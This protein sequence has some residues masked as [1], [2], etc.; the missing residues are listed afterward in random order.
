[1]NNYGYRM[2]D[3][4]KC[5]NL[6]IL[7]GRTTKDKDKGVCTCKGVSTIDYFL[8]SSHIIPLI[9][10]F[11]VDD[12]SQNLSDAHCPVSLEI[13][14]QLPCEQEHV[15][16]HSKRHESERIKL[17]DETMKDEFLHNTDLNAFDNINENI[18]CLRLERN[19]T[20]NEIDCI[21]ESFNKF[22][23]TSAEKSSGT[24]KISDQS[25]ASSK[26]PSW[27]GRK[28]TKARK[29][30]HTA[31]FQY[32]IRKSFENKE[33]LKTASK[34]YIYIVKSSHSQFQQNNIANT[35]SLIYCNPLTPPSHPPPPKKK[36]YTGSS[37][38]RKRKIR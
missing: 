24:Y 10:D 19:I 22:I 4:C 33:R 13:E 28:C 14:L 5:N 35:R 37:L 12:F 18:S 8:C 16:N 31:R 34:S 27:F 29:P 15:I 17:W 1:M 20:Q 32:R 2:L 6:Y 23:L 36:I 38:T 9:N 21:A 30:L 11:Y 7:N 26:P 25:N 3:F